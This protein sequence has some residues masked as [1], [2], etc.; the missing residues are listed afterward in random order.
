MTPSWLTRSRDISRRSSIFVMAQG[1]R[2]T[3]TS[4]GA[5]TAHIKEAIEGGFVHRPLPNVV[6]MAL[7]AIRN[8]CLD[9]P[10]LSSGSHR[11]ARATAKSRR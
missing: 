7:I 1:A 5:T 9:E 11:T 8:E 3:S 2:V 4:T 10:S 6:V